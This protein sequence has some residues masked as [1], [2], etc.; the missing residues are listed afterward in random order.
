MSSVSLGD[1]SLQPGKVADA[2][3]EP[4][5]ELTVAA[6]VLGVFQGVIL[7]LSFCYAALKLGFSIGGST[8]AS[9]MGYALLRGV[10]KK[11]TSVENNIN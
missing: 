11:G 1:G 4:Y 5:R 2:V 7:N 8:V 3:V 10:M 9:I 6:V